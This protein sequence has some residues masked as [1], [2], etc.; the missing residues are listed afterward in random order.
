MDFFAAVYIFPF[1]AESR[2]FLTS[3]SGMV[4]SWGSGIQ[5]EIIRIRDK[6]PGSAT[7]IFSHQITKT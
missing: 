1:L 3:G 7:L 6:H 2:I 5:I 4:K